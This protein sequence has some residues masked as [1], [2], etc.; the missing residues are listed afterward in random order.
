MSF[1]KR[2]VL[3]LAVF[4]L[5][6]SHPGLSSASNPP[7]IVSGSIDE[8]I[9]SSD[10]NDIQVARV[11]INVPGTL[12][13]VK[14]V[15]I[16]ITTPDVVGQAVGVFT[17][18]PG[19]G[20]FEQTGPTAG[21]EYVNLILPDVNNPD[22]TSQIVFDPIARNLEIIYRWTLNDIYGS[23]FDN[24]MHVTL[25]TRAPVALEMFGV[26]AALADGELDVEADFD[27]NSP[28]DFAAVADVEA[29]VGE[30]LPVEIVLDA[31]DVDNDPITYLMISAPSD[32]SFDIDTFTWQPD[33]DDVGVHNVQFVATDPYGTSTLAVDVV[34]EEPP[35]PETG[36][37]AATTT[38]DAP[39]G[40]SAHRVVW[41]GSESIVW[42][43]S[44]PL[45]G[46]VGTGAV[47][48]PVGNVWTSTAAAVNDFATSSHAAVWTGDEMI[49]WGGM[50][51][52]GVTNQ[53]QIYDPATDTWTEMSTV[54]APTARYDA[55]AV[56]TG[57]ELVV[58]GGV[59]IDGATWT[60][61]DDGGRYN[62]AT[63]T[64]QSLSVSGLTGRQAPGAAF[65]D[66]KMVVWGGSS[67][68]AET[69]NVYYSDGAVYDPSGDSWTAMSSTNAPGGRVGHAMTSAVAG[70]AIVW[71]GTNGSSF[72]DSGAVY[73]VVGNSW[74]TMSLTDAPDPR[75]STVQGG[76]NGTF[77]VW[78]GSGD[79]GLLA[80]GGVYDQT[81]N[82]WL[83]TSTVGTPTARQ[84]PGAA[85]NGSGLFIWGGLGEEGS[86]ENT[87][88][89]FTP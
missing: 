3:S 47:Y 31:T 9:V 42:G 15:T 65:T 32:A 62:P 45:D 43:G 79:E 80:T 35:I 12:Q 48:D 5:L 71:G 13:E 49:V 61:L 2:L 18:K 86:H 40:R 69:G 1:F 89:I 44:T 23:T 56:W 82:T 81:G 7:S 24:D 46:I 33:A 58:W 19:V 84:L 85:W 4:S 66:G 27:T 17:W 67:W 28:P 78:G 10:G 30:V 11:V 37:W 59:N 70:T 54:G 73:D 74:T 68:A 6:F 53:G 8:P 21:S 51:P 52:T 36:S 83:A 55:A 64:W 72:L 16:G 25:K 22:T 26:Q 34:V 87:G 39:D 57:T 60:W 77:I 63:D 41:T 14:S 50:T 38:T 29:V 76:A 88:G 20:F 75:M